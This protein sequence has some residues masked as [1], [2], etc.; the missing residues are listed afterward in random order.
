MKTFEEAFEAVSRQIATSETVI[1]ETQAEMEDVAS[2]YASLAKEAAES[3]QHHRAMIIW[4]E[5]GADGQATSAL[6]SAFM[7]GLITGC[8][9]EK[10]EL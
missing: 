10:Q 1:A 3:E 4:L 6:F 5:M 8:E 2:R 7:A 9:M